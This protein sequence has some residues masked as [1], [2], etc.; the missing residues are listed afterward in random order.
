MPIP[1]FED[2]KT[3]AAFGGFILAI[4]S[5]AITIYDKFL[6]RGT[7]KLEVEKPSVKLLGRGWYAVQLDVTLKSQRT[8]NWIK[9][10]YLE[11]SRNVIQ[12]RTKATGAFDTTARLPFRVGLPQD[13]D[14][15]LELDQTAFLEKLK[16]PPASAVILKDLALDEGEQRSIRLVA[17]LETERLSD[18]TLELPLYGWWLV[19]DLGHTSASF[20]V[21]FKPHHT[22]P[23]VL[24]PQQSKPDGFVDG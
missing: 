18:E 24:L 6:K 8:K 3:F 19:V 12:V 7:V 16:T 5:L 23:K 15:Y 20:R 4:V 14:D 10:V 13:E 21:S 17:E 22:T 2:V 1:N 11:H 9:A